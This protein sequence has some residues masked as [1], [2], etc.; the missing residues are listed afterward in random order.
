M[1]V[2]NCPCSTVLY[3]SLYYPFKGSLKSL[4]VANMCCLA[5]ITLAVG[6]SLSMFARVGER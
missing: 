1:C 2:I 5:K 6:A 3:V 4:R